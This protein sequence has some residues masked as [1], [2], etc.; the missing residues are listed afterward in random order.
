MRKH[1][2][3]LKNFD[4]QCAT[5]F[6]R[7]LHTATTISGEANGDRVTLNGC[8]LFCSRLAVFAARLQI[9]GCRQKCSRRRAY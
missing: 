9:P 6:C 5:V 4:R 8:I 3:S 2:F 1:V 7:H